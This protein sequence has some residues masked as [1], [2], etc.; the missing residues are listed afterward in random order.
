M[1]FHP[2]DTYSAFKPA[3]KG[4]IAHLAYHIDYDQMIEK[5]QIKDRKAKTERS[6]ERKSRLP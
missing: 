3:D 5:N 4:K 2:K 6:T 1:H